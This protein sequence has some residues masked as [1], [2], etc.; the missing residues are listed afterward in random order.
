MNVLEIVENILLGQDDSEISFKYQ[1]RVPL[2]RKNVSSNKYTLVREGDS[3]TWKW[4]TNQ[5]GEVGGGRQERDDTKY[6]G[7]TGQIRRSLIWT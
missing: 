3:N 5:R 7:K 6:D 1:P 4:V 2:R